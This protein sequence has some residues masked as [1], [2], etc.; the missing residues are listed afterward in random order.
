MPT[1]TKTEMRPLTDSEKTLLKLGSRK[2]GVTRAEVREALGYEEGANVAIQTMLKIVAEKRG[3]EL[4]TEEVP[5]ENGGR[6]LAVYAFRTQPRR[7]AAAKARR[8]GRK[9]A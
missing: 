7:A 4:V 9:S 1:N 5:N 2:A 3:L 6:W 8:S